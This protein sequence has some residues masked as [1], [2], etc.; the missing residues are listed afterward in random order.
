MVLTTFW[1]QSWRDGDPSAE[2]LHTSPDGHEWTRARF[3]QVTA[4]LAT[5]LVAAGHGRGSRI[6]LALP[7]TAAA[8]VS[9]VAILRAGACVVAC[10]PAST[11][12]QA[13][14]VVTAINPDLVISD[15][16]ADLRWPG[17]PA[18]SAAQ[19]RRRWHAGG[20][21]VDRS[22]LDRSAPDDLGL[23]CFTSGTTAA[24]KAVPMTMVALLAGM[25]A[26]VDAWRWTDADVLLSALPLHHVHGLVV[27]VGGSLTAGGQLVLQ[28]RFDPQL[29]RADALDHRATMIFGVPTMWWRLERDGVLADLP[30]LRLAVSGSA[31]LDPGLFTRLAR[32]LDAPPVERYGM[33]ETLILTSNP[34]DGPRKPG[35]VGLPVAGVEL[36]IASDQV[37]EVRGD[38]VM[39]GYLNR[40]A[41]EGFTEDGWFRTGDI[42]ELDRDGYLFLSGRATDL[43]ITGGHNVHPAEV[44]AALAGPSGTGG[45]ATGGTG[46]GVV[47]GLREV[48][49]AGMPDERWGQVVAAFVVLDAPTATDSS[50]IE[51]ALAQL[52]SR[53]DVLSPHQRPRR[54]IIVDAL[55]RNAMGKVVRARLV[56][57]AEVDADSKPA[58]PSGSDPV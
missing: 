56:R 31:P 52:R 29:V 2:L 12:A 15:D 14:E 28:E 40:P 35:S 17:V 42:G 57:D 11:A 47:A 3:E 44:E 10:D 25:R 45:T 49:V 48:A 32:V 8:V 39:A 22:S 26:L 16:P 18:L 46:T 21:P 20:E 13:D 55:P 24:R 27:A 30:P 5:D 9:F 51:T 34:I 58:G 38:T 6:V 50:L 4:G 23:I 1:V 53:A 37:V 54:W 43:I 41:D 7:P 19:L 33:T 36:R